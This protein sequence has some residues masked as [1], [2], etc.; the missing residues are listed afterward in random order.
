MIL[1]VNDQ[2]PLASFVFNESDLYPGADIGEQIFMVENTGTINAHHLNLTVTLDDDNDL[3]KNIDFDATG[4][5]LRFGASTSGADSENLVEELLAP[6]AGN[7]YFITKP[8][9]TG[10]SGIDLDGNGT[11]SLSE[12]AAAGTIRITPEGNFEGINAGTVAYLY[13]NTSVGTDLVTQG[14]TVNATF[15]WE[16]QQDASQM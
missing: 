10:F 6:A 15:T 5:G 13:M 4:N 1:E 14:E 11:L 12:L 16:L 2:N 3:A 7:D 8:D 9:G